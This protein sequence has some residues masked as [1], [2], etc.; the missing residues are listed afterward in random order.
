M[1]TENETITL[2]LFQNIRY[3]TKPVLN[4]T[5]VSITYISGKQTNLV[6]STKLFLKLLKNKVLICFN[7]NLISNSVGPL[8]QFVIQLRFH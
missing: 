5:D 3:Y 8:I 4:K 7:Y 1:S 6:Y 2:I